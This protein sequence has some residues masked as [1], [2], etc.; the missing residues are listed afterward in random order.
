[1]RVVE[2]RVDD[3]VRERRQ[4][5][6]EAQRRVDHLSRHLAAVVKGDLDAIGPHPHERAV[7]T[8]V[9]VPGLREVG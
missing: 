2:R 9:D 3:V 7:A 4:V 8:N 1:M 5:R 6:L